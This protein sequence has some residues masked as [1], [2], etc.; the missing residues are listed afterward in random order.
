MQNELFEFEFADDLE[1]NSRSRV[2]NFNEAVVTSTDW[3]TETVVSQLQR[4]NIQLT[5]RF[6]RRDAWDISRKSKFLESLFLGLPVPQIVLA[7][8]QGARG[9]FLV[10][11]GKQRL[12]TLLQF[13]GGGVGRNNEFAL[14]SLDIRDDLQG[15]TFSQ[16]S[17]DASF[18]GDIDTFLNQTIRTV[19]IRNWPSTEFLFLVFVRL[20][21][22]SVALS[23]Q[24][25]RQALLPGPFVDF[26]DDN[27]AESP[28]LRSLLKTDEPDF[29]M[30]DTE[31]LLRYIAFQFYLDS[32]NGNLKQFLDHTCMTLNDK[33]DEL[34]DRVKECVANFEASTS[35]CFEVFT[36]TFVA[37]RWNGS[38]FQGQF[39]RAIFDVLVYYFSDDR[40]RFAAASRRD[41][42]LQAYKD[43]CD[44]SPD[45]IS[46]VTTT[47]KSIGATF[48]RFELWGR[49]LQR[50]FPVV[51]VPRLV[52]NRICVSGG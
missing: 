8:Q 5:P 33:W 49:A 34:H 35:F 32:Y 2:Q 50:L 38:A 25:L 28:V 51:V 26:V 15:R 23:P 36:E 47:T 18:R 45:F 16:L 21:T 9:R 22:G 13:V 46:A 29:R 12:L 7:E 44:S 30:R 52:D 11:D 20:N 3:T 14:K 39:N 40:L 42:I 48:R 4:G 1:G 24:E 27:S 6:Q 17:N 10:L 37:R 19:V 31:L 43:L 41:E